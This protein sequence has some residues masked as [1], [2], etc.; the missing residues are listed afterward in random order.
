MGW[1]G[2]PRMPSLIQGCPTTELGWFAG[3]RASC[4]HKP[5]QNNL[6]EHPTPPLP[7][8]PSKFDGSPPPLLSLRYIRSLEITA[9]ASDFTIVGSA[10]PGA[11]GGEA[12]GRPAAGQGEADG[13][14]QPALWLLQRG[15]EAAPQRRDRAARGPQN[16]FP[17]GL[18]LLG[19]AWTSA[20]YGKE[21]IGPVMTR[22]LTQ[23]E[24]VRPCMVPDFLEQDHFKKDGSPEGRIISLNPFCITVNCALL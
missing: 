19:Q 23:A 8:P 13:S 20:E 16:R 6:T 22:R 3:F 18:E 5:V 17:G 10:G 15:N 24:T 12:A 1:K 21:S 14:C 11:K 4:Q 9:I 2:E 7:P